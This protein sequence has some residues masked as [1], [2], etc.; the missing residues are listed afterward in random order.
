MKFKTT[1]L[2]SLVILGLLWQVAASQSWRELLNKAD[3]LSTYSQNQDSAKVVGK[4]A[5]EKAKAQFGKEDT[6]I[7]LLLHRLG[8]YNHLKRNYLEAESLYKEA[9]AIWE[10][11]VG[12]EHPAAAN[13]LCDLAKLYLDQDRYSESMP[14]YKRSLTI[15]EKL[16]G[17]YNLELVTTL[18]MLAD[19]FFIQDNSV[20]AEPLLKRALDI[21]LKTIGPD[22]PDVANNLSKLASIYMNLERY[23]E[24]K[25]LLDRSLNIRENN[26][27]PDHPEVAASLM[28]LGNYYMGLDIYAEAEPLYKRALS[29]QENTLGPEHPS[30]GALYHNYAEVCKKLNRF[31]KAEEYYQKALDNFVK[32]RGSK[33]RYVSLTMTDMAELYTYQGRYTEAES[34]YHQALENFQNTLGMDHDYTLLCLESLSGYYRLRK[35]TEK[36]LAY[37]EQDFER[38]WKNYLRVSLFLSEKKALEYS[39][40]I[41]WSAD[42]YLS[43]YLDAQAKNVDEI[44]QACEVIFLSK[45]PVSDGIFERHKAIVTEKDSATLAL[46]ESLRLTKLQL[47]ELFVQGSSPGN[48]DEYKAR[49]DSLSELADQLESDL[50]RHSASFRKNLDHQNVSTEKIASLLP[51]KAILV[52]Y[53][54][55]DYLKLNPASVIPYYLVV[56]MDQNGKPEILDLGETSVIDRL[57]S[58]YREHLTR[59]ADKKSLL[60]E[61]STEEYKQLAKRVYRMIW[62]PLEKYIK[63]KNLVFIAPDGGLNLLSFA[64]LVDNRGVYLI[65]KYPLH[66]LSSGRDL[67]R[68]QDKETSSKGLLALGDPDYDAKPSVR[69]EL[70]TQEKENLSLSAGMLATRNIRSGCEELKD[71]KVDRLLGT[72]REVEKIEKYWNLYNRYKALVLFGSQASEE[73]FK[74]KA[75]GHR[76]IHLATHGYFLQGRCEPKGEK[77]FAEESFVGENPLLLS[78]LF[79]AGA[80]LHGEGSDSVNA[81]DGI[82]TADEV[83]ALNLEGTQMV[84]LSACETGLGEVKQG[85]G[86]YG[87]RRA[88]Q[89]AGARTVISA[90]WKVPD[91]I[92]AET[93]GELYKQ[94]GKNIPERLRDMQLTQIRKLRNNGDPDHPYSW[95]AFIA[96][97]DWRY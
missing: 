49:L 75:T 21:R 10:S 73:M 97:G 69:T 56:V 50:G 80:N 30:L 4:M 85:E 31:N 79:L 24:A 26:F 25:P 90:L 86:V 67:I 36:S 1:I 60:T 63:D 23:E 38:R 53:F 82:L 11:G 39:E 7:A 17:L 62:E 14:L 91:L 3:S 76:V 47:S 20:E 15:K 66:Y 52:E 41:K 68:L 45:G 33:H 35:E 89:M 74:L 95:G 9:L 65:E 48:S 81:E 8:V 71:I 78:G 34:L 18:D 5:L 64:G 96:L 46:A 19:I 32:N 94:K 2:V 12:E 42:N 22:H 93:M 51:D 84:V 37:A 29:I 58:E 27:G 83:S 43:S 61:S 6:T 70:Y 87:L 13:V 88:F 57:V 92:T 77:S 28:G 54:Q 55:Y 16:Y 72:R 40:K 59:V 44:K